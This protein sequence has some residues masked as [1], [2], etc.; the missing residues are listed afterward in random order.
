MYIGFNLEFHHQLEY[1]EEAELGKFH[2]NVTTNS[3]SL[4]YDS[5]RA[6]LRFFPLSIAEQ[7]AS[8]SQ[9]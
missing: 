2:S 6:R 8:L 9:K 7:S 4:T 5:Y 1:S 3:L